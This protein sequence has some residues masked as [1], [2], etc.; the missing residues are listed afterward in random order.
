MYKIGIVLCLVAVGLLGWVA[1]TY[2]QEPEPHLGYGMM[3]GYPADPAH[4]NAVSD[5]GFDWFKYFAR[6][7]DVDPDR[8]GVYQWDTVQ[9]R[10]D[11][12]CRNQL[13]LVFRVERAANNWRPVQDDEMAGWQ[14]FFQAMA[15]YVGQQRAACGYRYRVAFEVWNE[16]N[17][18]FQWT[19][20]SLDAARYTE[21]VK[22]A[23]LGAKTGD[24]DTIIVAGSLAPTGGDGVH[25]LNDATYLEAMYTAGLQGHFDAISIHNYGFG[26]PPED[27]E[28]GWG[29]TNFRRAEDIYAVM[30]AHGDS[31]KPIWA[32]EFGWLL[33]SDE[34]GVECDPDWGNWGFAWQQV[35][36]ISQSTYLTRAFAYAD[37]HW[38]WMQ[39]MVVSNLDFATLPSAWMA[40]CDPLR[41]FSVLKPDGS[42]RAAYTG[43][44]EMPKRPHS[45]AA[46]SMRVTPDAFEWTVRLRERARFTETV[47]VEN[48][49]ER[50]FTWTLSTTTQGLPFT[51][52]AS[53]GAAGES[54]QIVVDARDLLTGT[55]TGVVTVTAA[56]DLMPHNPITIPL[57]LNVIGLWGMAVRPTAL[58]WMQGVSD[59]HP[60]AATVVVENTGDYPFNW[61]I[62]TATQGLPFSV[63][64]TTSVWGETASLYL[65]T[66]RVRVDPRGLPVGDYTG[67]ITLTTDTPMPQSPFVVPL[68]M[69]I[70][71]QLYPVYLPLVLRAAP[72]TAGR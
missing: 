20:Q 5:A 4:M 52:T 25:S 64:P 42:P 30:V 1:P 53:D 47:T 10:L 31:H 29:I 15:E 60:A 43:L 11:E 14:A 55:Y 36:A 69:R 21:M 58:G 45:W 9:W 51:V 12:A 61:S 33:D 8:D 44:K 50:P 56:A 68:H 27:K 59:T 18:D 48:T 67:V 65:S 19:G 7:D 22:R 70:V 41:W 23:Y 3:L 2:A 63:A 32:T 6:W 54:F 57:T 72:R 34:E 46:Q 62:V 40:T 49:G 38:P 66:F 71:A 37:T 35:S 17:L 13:N 26:G 28:Y 16:P 24:P 39:V